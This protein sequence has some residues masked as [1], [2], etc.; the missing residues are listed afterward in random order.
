MYDESDKNVVDVDLTNSDSDEVETRVDLVAFVV[1]YAANQIHTHAVCIRDGRLDA[2][3]YQLS[4]TTSLPARPQGWG[5][6]PRHGETMGARY[7]PE[8]VQDVTAFFNRGACKSSLKMGPA[9]MR[10]ELKRKYPSRFSIPSR[11]ELRTCISALFMKAKNSS[12]RMVGTNRQISGRRGRRSLLPD[13]VR[14]FVTRLIEAN[15][16]MKATE[17]LK[18]VRA[19]FPDLPP[20]AT[21]SRIKNRIANAKLLNKRCGHEPVCKYLQVIIDFIIVKNAQI[22]RL[23]LRETHLRQFFSARPVCYSSTGT[24]CTIFLRL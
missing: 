20:E 2:P 8:F 3:E 17:P 11:A 7:L 14:N 24:P 6:R 15:P 23:T 16:G 12:P 18:R 22:R 10:E 1:R 9:Q 13:A 19:Q 5:R 21:D 4:R